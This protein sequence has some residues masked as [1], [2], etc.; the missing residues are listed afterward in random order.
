MGYENKDQKSVDS[1]TSSQGSNQTAGNYLFGDY[2][3]FEENK[4]IID[5]LKDFV[6]ISEH[7]LQIHGNVDKLN[8]L[9][10]NAEI[11]RE[12]MN[13]KINQFKMS[14]ES[15]MDTFFDE[16]YE[17]LAKVYFPDQIGAE[18]FLRIK[19]SIVR[20]ITDVERECHYQF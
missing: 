16:F 17:K 14:S 3:P 8:F 10:K 6:S 5:M 18:P 15:E 12:A 4:N 1:A 9:L 19:N 2:S 20:S 11:L 13:T 7:V